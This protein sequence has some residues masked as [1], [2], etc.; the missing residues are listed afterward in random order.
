MKG[1]KRSG[2]VLAAGA[3]ALLAS[4]FVTVNAADSATTNMVKCGGVNACKGKTDCKSKDNACK[5]QNACKS[6]GWVFMKTAAECT[7]AKGT[8]MKEDKSS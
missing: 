4:G 6:K 1:I 5:G 3:A 8:V 7:K 2:L